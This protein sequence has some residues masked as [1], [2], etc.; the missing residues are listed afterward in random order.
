[1]TSSNKPHPF[2]WLKSLF[3][4]FQSARIKKG[5]KTGSLHKNNQLKKRWKAYAASAFS[6]G[7][8]SLL[9]CA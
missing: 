5:T 4:F 1:L 9:L 7:V 8:S 6:F 2:K 3:L